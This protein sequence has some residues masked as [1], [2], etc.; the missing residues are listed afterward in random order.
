M[1][2][3]MCYNCYMAYKDFVNDWRKEITR[4]VLFFYG[5]E[6]YLMDWAVREIASRYVDEEWRSLDFRQLDGSLVSSYDI[7]SEAR[8][9]SMF[10]DR[11]VVVVK[12]WLPLYR[13]H[14][15]PGTDE[16]LKFASENQDTSVLIFV[17]ESRYSGD[18][19]SYARKLIKAAGSYDFARLERADLK[20]FINK[21]VHAAGKM[22]ARR[23]LEFLIDIS[24]YYN[25][26]S[27][28]TLTNLDGDIDKIVKAAQTDQI[29]AD[30]IE[31]LMTGDSD[32]FVFNLVDAVVSGN[33]ARALAIAE[34]IINEEDGAM[35]VTALLIKQFE[36]MYDAL[37][38]S[39]QGM[40]ISQ[41]AKMT[42]VNEFRFKKAWQAAN[43]YSLSRIRKLLTALYNTDRDI[44]R[45][46]I[47]KDTA[48][49]L[50]VMSAV[51]GR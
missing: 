17:L 18:L 50:F 44:K 31:D 4:D 42:G 33:R 12:D 25:K 39:Q 13:K 27:T 11:R 45:G 29:S 21:R 43:S 7:M 38:L 48:L 20:S 28:Y 35:Q 22:L 5:A 8:A 16:L 30:I 26:E 14:S 34:T 49:E 41:M 15:D 1:D 9:Y 36:I 51:P 32:R 3:A 46:D 24:G 6:D 2:V 37:E 19:T 47:D 40:S 10:S 23:E